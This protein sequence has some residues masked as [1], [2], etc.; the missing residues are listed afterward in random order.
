M[1][2]SAYISSTKTPECFESIAKTINGQC[3]K[4]GKA[5]KKKFNT[6]IIVSVSLF[7]STY[8]L[9]TI[10][11]FIQILVPDDSKMF[12]CTALF[13]NPVIK[14]TGENL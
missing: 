11:Q 12:Q 6:R 7:L 8:I 10:G 3:K 1:V 4:K 2:G 14:S 5:K 9:C 13:L